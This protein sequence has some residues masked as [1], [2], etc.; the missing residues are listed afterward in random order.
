MSTELAI[1][2]TE[3]TYEIHL[4]QFDG[5]FDL[6]LFFI[7]RDELDIRDIPIARITHDFLLYIQSAERLRINLAAE[8]LV[9]AAQL[10]KIKARM[11]L[12]RPMVTETGEEVDPRTE[13]VDRLLAYKQ[14][15]DAAETL[16]QLGTAHA[17]RFARGYVEQEVQ[18][19]R[20]ETEPED[21]LVGLT[22]YQLFK[23]Y[24]RI[25]ERQANQLGDPS[26]VIRAYPYRVEEVRQDLDLALAQ[27]P[28]LDFVRLIKRHPNRYY[29]VFAFLL[30]LEMVQQKLLT[31]TV[32]EGFN[33]FWLE[34]KATEAH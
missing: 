16:E 7:Q 22:T 23:V 1:A 32:G 15:K 14:F 29:L 26:H 3:S 12:P 27:N 28:R 11:L 5:P 20:G 17:D 31:V 33:S 4:P 30:V 34:R 24:Q 2:A 18:L 19:I 21:E 8:F 10:M 25:I 13:L 9:V 6:L